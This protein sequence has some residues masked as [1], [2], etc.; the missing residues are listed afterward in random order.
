MGIVCKANS[1]NSKIIRTAAITA[2]GRSMDK[3]IRFMA[4]PL[5]T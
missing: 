2:M 5:L 1:P 3:R 4:R